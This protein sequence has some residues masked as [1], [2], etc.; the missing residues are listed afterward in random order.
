MVH[1]GNL[2]SRRVENGIA[3][4]YPASMVAP[5][6]RTRFKRRR[7]SFTSRLSALRLGVGCLKRLAGAVLGIV[8]SNR[9]VF[10]ERMNSP[11]RCSLRDVVAKQAIIAFDDLIQVIVCSKIVYFKIYIPS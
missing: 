5:D 9:L 10:I 6:S 3:N 7:V 8:S 4:E 11:Y 1:C 2:E